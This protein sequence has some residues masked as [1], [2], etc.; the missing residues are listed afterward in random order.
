MEKFL[1]SA[2]DGGRYR[3]VDKY[4]CRV[5]A[6]MRTMEERRKSLSDFKEGEVRILI[7]TDVAARGIDIRE[8]P[9][10]INVTLPDLPQTYLHRAGRVGRADRLGLAVALVATVDER[11]WHCKKGTKPPCKDTTDYDKG[12]KCE[13]L[14]GRENSGVILLYFA[15]RLDVFTHALLLVPGNCFWY[16]E[17]KCRSEIEKLLDANH[18]KVSTMVYKS[19]AMTKVL[20]PPEIKKV[21]DS[22][23]Y[24]GV[25]SIES[26]P[27]WPKLQ[28][29][30]ARIEQVEDTETALQ[31]EFGT[32]ETNS[33]SVPR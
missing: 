11:V 13:F 33:V 25:A 22:G 3:L 32:Y 9:F 8:L 27:L 7:A 14:R 29:I 1:R 10:V 15:H 19:S 21:L 18:V 20:L 16:S 12:G 2:T 6:G 17:P 24:G 4:T 5:I 26:E 28:A 31:G 23:G 30:R